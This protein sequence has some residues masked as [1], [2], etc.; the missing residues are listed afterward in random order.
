M[1]NALGLAEAVTYGEGGLETRLRRWEAAERPVIQ[2]TQR[3][4]YRLGHLN[5][6]PD[7]PRSALLT[8][9][10]RSRTLA[11]MRMRAATTVP[12]GM[13]RFPA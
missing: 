7:G 8:V 11:G 3:F 12:T 10:N 13:N 2:H 1:M 5:P 9:M 6:L 4:S